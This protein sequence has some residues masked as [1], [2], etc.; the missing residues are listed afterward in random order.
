V[1]NPELHLAQSVKKLRIELGFPQGK[2]D[3]E[4]EALTLS[5]SAEIK[6]VSSGPLIALGLIVLGALILFSVQYRPWT[7]AGQEA[8]GNDLTIALHGTPPPVEPLI[9]KQVTQDYARQVNAATPFSV[10]PVPAAAPFKFVGS[11]LD[12]ARATD[13]LAATVYY[14]AGNEALAGQLAVAQVVLNRARHPAFPHTVCGVVFQGHERSTGCQFSY[15]CDGSI[16]RRQ[17]SPQAWESARSVARS[18]LAGNVYKP[19]GTATHYHTDWVIPYWSAKLDKVRAEQSHLF[20]RWTGFWGTPKAFRATYVGGEEAF[21]KLSALSPAHIAPLVDPA[22]GVLGQVD[23]S[24]EL[25]TD[26]GA[27]TGN[28]TAFDGATLGGTTL[29]GTDLSALAIGG[30]PALESPAAATQT[31]ADPGKGQFLL[32]ISASSNPSSLKAM[33]EQT[34]GA[35]DY[36]KVL[37]WSDASEMPKGFP[38]SDSQLSAVA[39]SY[40]R[41]NSRGF[42]KALWNCRIYPNADGRQCM[43]GRG[44]SSPPSPVVGK[45]KAVSAKP[46]TG[47]L[48]A[49]PSNAVGAVPQ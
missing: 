42:E 44:G 38:I 1:N 4:A 27:T 35:R 43:R 23:L 3:D 31:V 17:P 5:D 25:A 47:N 21:S 15:T 37:A 40:L 16:F 29:G 34:C 11:Q 26:F 49:M 24:K 32:R 48:S 41:D 36:C 18:M 7:Q 10:L 45:S 14:E 9:L 19:V 22:A 2:I 6:G 13:C 30:S 39:F 28:M 33:A 20:F 12:L 8:L 46:S